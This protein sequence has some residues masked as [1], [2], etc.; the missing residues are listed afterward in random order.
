MSSRPNQPTDTFILACGREV[1]PD[2]IRIAEAIRM[3]LSH[4]ASF[5]HSQLRA[6]DTYPGNLEVLPGWDSL[7]FLEWVMTAE[8]YLGASIPV[9]AYDGIGGNFSVA[10][11]FRLTLDAVGCTSPMDHPVR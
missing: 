3:S 7:D 8:E 6:D 5:Q 4:A 10:D 1:T 2:A 11:L 9:D